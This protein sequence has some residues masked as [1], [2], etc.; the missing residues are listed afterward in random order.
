MLDMGKNLIKRPTN[1]A[2]SDQ[3]NSLVKFKWVNLYKHLFEFADELGYIK[4]KHLGLSF[5]LDALVMNEVLKISEPQIVK[6]LLQ[7]AQSCP[8]TPHI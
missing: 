7:H 6:E 8:S 1:T 5:D 2:E 4:L 3:K